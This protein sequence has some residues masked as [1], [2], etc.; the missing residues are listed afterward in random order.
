MI[1]FIVPAH[2]EQAYLPR[3]LQAIHEAAQA[4]GQPYEIVMA[5][6]ASI[7]AAADVARENATLQKG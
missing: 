1:S 6:G 7:D 4:T 2:H 5:N 3:T